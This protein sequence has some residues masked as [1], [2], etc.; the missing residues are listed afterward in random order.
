M[1]AILILGALA[2]MVAVM[3]AGWVF[4]KRMGNGGWVDVFW[5]FGTG[6]AGA[7]CA[8]WPTGQDYVPRQVLVALLVA[9]WSA[10][11]GVYVALR[12]AR[13]PEDAR[14]GRLR[15][16]WRDS[17]QSRLFWFMQLQAPCSALLC[18]SITLAAHHPAQGLRLLDLAGFLILLTAI[19]GEGLA[20]AQMTRFKADPAN[21][22]RV[23]D[24]GLWAWSRHPNYFF[25]W[26]G[27]L[28]YPVMAFD[29]SRPETLLS[30]AGPVFMYL[31]LTRFTGVPALE[32]HMARTRPDA[33][34]DYSARVG[35]FFPSPPKKGPSA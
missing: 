3:A 16:Q 20:D 9:A 25:E 23:N 30:L 8:L 14:Y 33:W 10:R 6:A 24:R 27:W 1:T 18:L 21:H 17:F 31:I 29:P 35:A 2:F 28:A 34:R 7:A 26:F 13:G 19:A 32:Q 11:L 12:V 5:T 15:E 22:G 4:Q